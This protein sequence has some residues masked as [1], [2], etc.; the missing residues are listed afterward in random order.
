M[1]CLTTWH[2]VVGMEEIST[3]VPLEWVHGLRKLGTSKNVKK[4]LERL[5]TPVHLVVAMPN[6]HAPDK[7]P[8]ALYIPRTL[9]ER[10]RKEAKAKGMSITDFVEWLLWSAVK[11]VELT[12][13]DHRRIADEI[14]AAQAGRKTDQRVRSGRASRKAQGTG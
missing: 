6:Q 5:L 3:K 14:Q 7:A 13:E 8:I 9:K 4:G 10:V 12:D 2:T 11:N 1:S